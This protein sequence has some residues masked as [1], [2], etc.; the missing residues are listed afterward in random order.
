MTAHCDD[1]NHAPHLS[2]LGKRDILHTPSANHGP[3]QSTFMT[4]ISDPTPPAYY[5]CEICG[6]FHPWNWNGDCRD[7]DCRF[8]DDELDK[9]HPNGWQYRDMSE[10]VAADLGE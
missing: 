4:R 10:R 6:Y 9:K 3:V 8:T 5:E 2:E 1:T 7:N